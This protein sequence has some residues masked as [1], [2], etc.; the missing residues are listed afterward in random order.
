[1]KSFTGKV[2]LVTGGNTG[3][4][5]ATALAF[6]R[7]GAQVV[8]TGRRENQGEETVAQIRAAGSQ[9]LFIR[10]DVSKAQDVQMMIERTVE[11]FGRLDCAVNNAGVEQ[12]VTPL[13]NQT[14][15]EFDRIISVNVKG[16]WLSMKDEIEQ[17]LTQG[18]GAIVN[19][20]SVSGLIGV[21]GVEIYAA[22][23]H[24]VLG[25]TKSAAMEFAKSGIRINAVCPGAV[26]T[27]MFER[28][29]SGA[30]EIAELFKAAHPVG[31][32]GEP[33]EIA[34]AVLWLCSQGAS[35]MTGQTVTVDGGF[36]AQ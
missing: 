32:M 27:E 12:L 24:A 21:G 36:T 34:S 23:K 25:L 20:S 26:K 4:G 5:R 30:S 8:I 31:R 13:V 19:M 29:T 2:V 9:G 1:V 17:M 22:S 6:A 28:I 10:A 11:T 16:V 7:E 35:F 18:G 15:A 33:E 14:E 3:I